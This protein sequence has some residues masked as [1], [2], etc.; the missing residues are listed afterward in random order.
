MGNAA[1]FSERPAAGR[2][3]DAAVET[4]LTLRSWEPVYERRAVALL[5][6]CFRLVGLDLP[7]SRRCS[8]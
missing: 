8:R 2:R 6:V 3:K 7:S 5:S 1:E 4:Q